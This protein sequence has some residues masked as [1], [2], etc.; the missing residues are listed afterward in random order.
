MISNAHSTLNDRDLA[1]NLRRQHH[2]VLVPL[3]TVLTTAR[4][5]H[6][7]GLRHSGATDSHHFLIA[8][9]RSPDS[10]HDAHLS[11]SHRVTDNCEKGRGRRTMRMCDAHDSKCHHEHHLKADTSISYDPR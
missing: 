2:Q 7:N 1:M 4:L 6:G 9:D 10:V 5:E 11:A 8:V 3:G